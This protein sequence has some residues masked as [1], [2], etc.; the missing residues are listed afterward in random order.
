MTPT[1]VLR[2]GKPF[3]ALG[4]RGGSRIT[5]AVVQIIMNVVDFR[6]NIQEAVDAPRVHHQWL[7]DEILYEPGALSKDVIVNLQ[8]MGHTVRGINEHL[9]GRVQALMIDSSTGFFYSGADPR[10]DGVGMGY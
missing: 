4:A 2:N 9:L 5:T 7:P 3:L 10:E 1:I 6:M 8:G